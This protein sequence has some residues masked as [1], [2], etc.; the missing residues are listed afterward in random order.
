MVFMR[1]LP[2]RLGLIDLH[3]ACGQADA[4]VLYSTGFLMQCCTNHALRLVLEK[5]NDADSFTGNIH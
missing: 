2:S 4:H 1:S 5:L 3:L